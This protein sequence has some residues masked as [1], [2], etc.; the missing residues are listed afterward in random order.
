[1]TNHPV[2]VRISDGAF[3]EGIH[4]S[5]S[6]GHGRGHFIE[7][8]VRKIHAA[9]V[10]AQADGRIGRVVALEALPQVVLRLLHKIERSLIVK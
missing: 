10:D 3:F 8:I 6:F 4:G 5:E 7:I 2:F 9:E 1:M